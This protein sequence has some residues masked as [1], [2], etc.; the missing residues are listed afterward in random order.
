MTPLQ[1]STRAVRAKKM[2]ALLEHLYPTA[3]PTLDYTTPFELL[4]AVILSAQCTDVRVNK[5]TPAL[6]AKY[7]TLTAFADAKLKDVEKLVFS[8]GFYRNKTKNII[9]AAQKVQQDFGGELPRTMQELIT[10]PGVARKTANVVL[11]TLYDISEG[12][13]VD[14]HVRRFAI[15]FD[16][17]DYTDPLR[18][19]RDLMEILPPAVW[20]IWPH[21][22]ILYAREY[23]PAREH[24]CR[25]HP[26]TLLYPEAANKW[27]KAG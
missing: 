14:T 5:V 27:P 17:S 4:V 7:P 11:G 12:V 10:I 22:L 24:E 1:K 26:L 13:M 9:G 25:E 23:C 20:Y 16:L 15:R 21:R 18:I 2:N 8:T 19:E 6:F 3:D